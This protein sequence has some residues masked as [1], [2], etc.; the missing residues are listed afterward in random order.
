MGSHHLE[1]LEPP[2]ELA[3]LSLAQKQSRKVGCCPPEQRLPSCFITAQGT[4]A[5][6]G[7]CSTRDDAA[8]PPSAPVGLGG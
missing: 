4:E 7:V 2:A 6:S 8:G 5:R 1:R 3:R